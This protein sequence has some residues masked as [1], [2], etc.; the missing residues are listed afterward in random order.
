MSVS[1]ITNTL[2][3]QSAMPSPAQQWRNDFNDLAKALDNGDMNSAQKAVASLQQLQSGLSK[4][5]LQ[6]IT[7]ADAGG[8]AQSTLANDLEALG[9]ALK[10]GSLAN[11]Q[12]AFEQL[13][14]DL[15]T[16][17]QNTN[18]NGISAYTD[19]AYAGGVAGWAQRSSTNSTIA[20]AT[21]GNSTFSILG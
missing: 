15:H 12:T 9:Q 16:N 14:S 10:S 19:S 21:N 4:T 2:I 5:T 3:Q 13:Q 18:Q 7:G 8:E 20:E 1:G 6:A 11:S 17:E